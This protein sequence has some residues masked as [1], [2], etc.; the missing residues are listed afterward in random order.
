MNESDQYE[1]ILESIRALANDEPLAFDISRLLYEHNCFCL[2][3]KHPGPH[4]YTEQLQADGA[5]NRICV[6]ERYRQCLPIFEALESG[7]ISYAVIKGAV[8]S[9]AAYGDA[10]A[11]RSG[12]IDLLISQRDIDEVKRL[13]LN[14]GFVQGRVTDEGIVPFTRREL[15]FQ[16]A[17]SHQAAPFI[18]ET[19]N[20]LCPY[21]NVDVNLDILWG[22]SET[23]TDMDF[24]L[25]ETE[26]VDICGISVRKLPGEMELIALC[27]HHYKD[28]NSLYLL[29]QG[30]LKLSLFCDLY[31]YLRRSKLD[32]IR[33]KTIC[34]KLKVRDYVYYCLYYT[35]RLFN[36]SLFGGYLSAVKTEKSEG[37]LN[38]FGLA[39][40]EKREWSLDFFERLFSADLNRYL[41]LN[42]SAADWDKIQ[43]NREYM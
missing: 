11:R 24:V 26:P 10:A 6:R 31:F 15:L 19:G 40:E 1:K 14:D 25:S 5:L 27:L 29:S 42:L 9:Q 17:M 2:L 37:I 30:S 33:L 39:H 28:M 36:D 3:S 13:L 41:S 21:V 8:L 34:D 16:T 35:S 18:K 22:E 38:T 7:G 43:V 4:A 23:K 12:D 32:T 20:P